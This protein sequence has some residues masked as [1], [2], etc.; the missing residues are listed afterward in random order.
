MIPKSNDPCFCGSGKKFKKC[1]I[2]KYNEQIKSLVT[3]NLDNHEDI[4]NQQ[5]KWLDDELLERSPTEV[6]YDDVLLAALRDNK[7]IKESINIANAQY[8][9]E[10]LQ[11]DASTINDIKDHYTYLLTHLEIKNKFYKLRK[12]T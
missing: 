8:P 3:P 10:A 4:Y 11:Y 12:E 6:A 9:N 1:C 5:N 7:S 2:D